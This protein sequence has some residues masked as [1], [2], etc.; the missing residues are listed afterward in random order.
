MNTLKAPGSWHGLK[1][2]GT[3]ISEVL[4]AWQESESFFEPRSNEVLLLKGI[5]SSGMPDLPYKSHNI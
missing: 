1:M 5:T 2:P 4:M 3:N